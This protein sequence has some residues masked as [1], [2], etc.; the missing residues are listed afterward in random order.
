M[1]APNSS[2]KQDD[3]ICVGVILGAR[4]LKGELYVR[5]Y[6]GDPGDIARRGPL[7]T[8]GEGA[9]LRVRLVGSTKH[10]LVVRADGVDDRATAEA[11][12][13]ARLYLR[14]DALPPLAEDEFFH[15]DL[16]GLT[17]ELADGAD[18]PSRQIGRVVAVQ[19]F[20]AGPVLEI[21]GCEALVPFTKA[22]V[23]EVELAA[24]RIVV[25]RLPGLFAP[26][27]APEPA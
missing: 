6:T 12:C 2:E 16:I 13:G 23:P 22:A 11:L 9:L 19:D 7:G 10:G 4:G 25:A 21:E 5:S 18:T 3:R 15:A 20:G 24:G 26:A 1:A 17:A 27:G 8:D 14:R